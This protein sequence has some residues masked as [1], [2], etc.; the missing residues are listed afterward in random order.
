MA[1][2]STWQYRLPSGHRNGVSLVQVCRRSLSAAFGILGAGIELFSYTY[3][4]KMSMVS[5]I[6]TFVKS[7]VA[8]REARIP[9]LSRIFSTSKNS[10]DDLS[11]YVFGT[12]GDMMEFNCFATSFAPFT[13]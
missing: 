6:G 7:D 10:S 9:L 13:S 1:T 2:P 5:S 4:N 8:S 11:E 3:F 12:Y